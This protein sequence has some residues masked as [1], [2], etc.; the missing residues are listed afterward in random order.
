MRE[1]IGDI[2]AVLIQWAMILTLALGVMVAV[3]HKSVPL[4]IFILIAAGI[5][6]SVIN[7]VK[8]DQKRDS[9]S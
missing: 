4:L 2:F 7:R 3:M 9:D 6:F 1:L 5:A 8:D